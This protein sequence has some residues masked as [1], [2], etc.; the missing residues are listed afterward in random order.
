MAKQK[1][2]VVTHGLSGKVGDL[3]VFR[4]RDGQT[5]VSKIPEQSKNTSE[6]QK[7]LRK[8]FQQATVY[9]KIATNT[10]GVRDLYAE[11]AKKR[12]GMT[13]YNV[14]V[15][16][17]FNAPDIDSVDLSEYAGAEGDEIRIIA[18]DDFAVKSVHVQI[19]NVDGFTIEEGDAV[20][21]IAS[22]WIYTATANNE[23]PD[24]CK[25]V[26]SASDMPGNV[27]TKEIL[28]SEF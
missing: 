8:K 24:G 19:S 23:S 20:N 14:A 18:S 4:Q 25:I 1:G 10:P 7:K 2:N 13:A 5:V 22:L 21:S 3:L 6:K 27:T 17:F 16:D 11:A 28:N 26:V 9:A 15:A 12:K